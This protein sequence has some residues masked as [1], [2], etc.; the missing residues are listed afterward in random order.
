MQV[1]G[2][3]HVNVGTAVASRLQQARHSV[4]GCR[5]QGPPLG[6]ASSERYT[7]SV[8]FENFP[9]LLQQSKVMSS[10]HQDTVI[11]R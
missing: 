10:P 7:P 4:L 1:G 9:L 5:R 11:F 3:R 2:I 8:D 6:P